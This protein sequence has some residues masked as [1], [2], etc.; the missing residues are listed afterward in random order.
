MRPF[1]TLALAALL[2]L[3]AV[4]PARAHDGFAVRDAYA[5][6]SSA[7]AQSG[8][9]FM[10]IENHR[11]ID[12]RLIAARSDVAERVELHT[13]LS[14]SA[15]VMRM[16]EVED[17]FAIPAEGEHALARGGDHVMLLG[18]TRPLLDGEIVT[19]TLVFE[20][21]G[22]LVVEVPVDNA[23][24]DSGAHGGHGAHG[25]GHG[26]HGGHGAPSN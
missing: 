15:G 23:R 11:D 20:Q 10:V 14:D 2:A 3:P 1:R 18:L 13:H 6:A 24:M 8:A 9:I 21:S 16:V 26:G 7:A 5:R 17:G 12:D 4:A 25:A 19:L 22:E